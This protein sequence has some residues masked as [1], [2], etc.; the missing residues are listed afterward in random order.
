MIDCHGLLAPTRVRPGTAGAAVPA[1]SLN[2][3]QSTAAH[4][5]RRR[6][7]MTSSTPEPGSPARW[8]LLTRRNL[9]ASTG[10]AAGGVS[11]GPLLGWSTAQAA[12][13]PAC[14][15]GTTAPGP[16]GGERPAA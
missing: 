9:L 3:H 2:N 12:V 4:H 10:L 14:A 15:P 1:T 16:P 5:H 13:S 11:A 7:R 6:T 8:P